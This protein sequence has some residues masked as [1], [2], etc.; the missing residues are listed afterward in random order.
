[1][2]KL[3][4]LAGVLLVAMAC[5]EQQQAPTEVQFAKG[6]QGG[7]SWITVV[8]YQ[9][10]KLDPASQTLTGDPIL[11]AQAFA[12]FNDGTR[13]SVFCGP[14]ELCE[15]ADFFGCPALDQ[16][17]N[18][19]LFTYEG[20]LDSIRFSVAHSIG[21]EGVNGGIIFDTE[22]LGNSHL[23]A[24][25]WQAATPYIPVAGIPDNSD[26]TKTVSVYWQG[27][28]RTLGW[29]DQPGYIHLWNYV[30]DQDP[31]DLDSD[32]SFL[33]KY[34][35]IRKN[36]YR[37]AGYGFALGYPN[38]WARYRGADHGNRA[39][40]V[41]DRFGLEISST[42]KPRGKGKPVETST[43]L[44]WELQSFEPYNPNEIVDASHVMKVRPPDGPEYLAYPY[45]LGSS[46]NYREQ[47]T[48]S[49]CYE[50]TLVGTY[51]RDQR[52]LTSSWD[53]AVDPASETVAVIYDAEGGE[54]EVAESCPS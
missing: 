22:Q 53:S 31:L 28:R 18:E 4:V 54:I 44:T 50:L 6:G 3:I 34:T 26:G 1:M 7:R 47:L 2:K 32:D 36:D 33:F 42:G 12:S 11:D 14:G 39:Y 40:T 9:V 21:G 48:E 19:I 13:R 35:L 15:P 10:N 46:T 45:S 16:P 37:V 23:G 24:N 51:V 29:D 49:G 43:Y 30:P 52:F 20:R 8:D 17:C 38:A 27:Q 41:M 25:S 5:S